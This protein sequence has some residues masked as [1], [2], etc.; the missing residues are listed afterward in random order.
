MGIIHIVCY[1][2]F[3]KLFSLNIAPTALS[4]HFARA[5]LP[6]GSCATQ[7]HVAAGII[8]L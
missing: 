7:P 6:Q 3:Q 2:R 4:L 8:V 5:N 1:I